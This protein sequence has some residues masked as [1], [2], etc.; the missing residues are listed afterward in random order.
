M[1]VEGVDDYVRQ[2]T[3]S[4][5]FNINSVDDLSGTHHST[6]EALLFV[7]YHNGL[8]TGRNE[9]SMAEFG[10]TYTS[11]AQINALATTFVGDAEATFE[12]DLPK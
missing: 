3:W 7:A 8:G 5:I 11:S 1:Y 2:K 9:V 6:P 10:A 12:L 4:D